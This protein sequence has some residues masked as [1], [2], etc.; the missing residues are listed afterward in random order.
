MPENK[1]PALLE[2]VSRQEGGQHIIKVEAASCAAKKMKATCRGCGKRC[3]L[4][5]AV[6][7]CHLVGTEM[8]QPVSGALFYVVFQ[9]TPCVLT[10]LFVFVVSVYSRII[11]NERDPWA[12]PG[13]EKARAQTPQYGQT[14]K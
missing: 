13:H 6:R 2:A 12:R 10:L 11:F 1:G 8:S 5:W 9:W 4:S 14:R 7:G 3:R